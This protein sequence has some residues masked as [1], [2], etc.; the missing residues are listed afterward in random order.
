MSHQSESDATH[1]AEADEAPEPSP[2]AAGHQVIQ[3]R[4]Q[5]DESQ[6]GLASNYKSFLESFSHYRQVERQFTRPVAGPRF[7]KPAAPA[8]FK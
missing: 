6:P 7:W 8:R 1:N 2:A 3:E 4:Q 5:L